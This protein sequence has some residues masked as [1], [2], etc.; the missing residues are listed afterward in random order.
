MFTI[1]DLEF[2]L[3][4]CDKVSITGIKASMK[5]NE[6]FIKAA[7]AKKAMG[8]EVPAP[9]GKLKDAIVSAIK[10]KEVAKVSED[11][12]VVQE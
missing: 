1:S 11:E 3:M 5:L 10:P 8:A 4:M 2:I 6:V 7:N 9:T 12:K